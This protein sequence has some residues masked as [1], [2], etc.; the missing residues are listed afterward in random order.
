MSSLDAIVILIVALPFALS[1]VFGLHLLNQFDTQFSALKMNSTTTNQIF[2]DTRATYT[3]FDTLFVAL[4]LIM[5][6]T[7]VLAASMIR[8]HPAFFVVSVIIT[9]VLILMTAVFSNVYYAVASN[10]AEASSFSGL[11][12]VFQNFPYL[13]LV[14]S[15]I[16]AFVQ[17]AKPA[18]PQVIS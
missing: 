10:F 2:A 13:M 7:S 11:T 1:L 18:G 6:F 5:G 17:Y 4:V 9:I 3:V 12:T 16:I 15:F 14:L 8:T